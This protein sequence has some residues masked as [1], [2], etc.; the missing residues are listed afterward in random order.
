[1]SSSRSAGQATAP[2]SAG[3]TPPAEPE[4]R[5]P[6]VMIPPLSRTKD[7]FELQF[8]TNHLGHFALTNLLL[9]NITGRVANCPADGEC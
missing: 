2:P 1:M 5:T 9:P 3:S 7:G 8:G 6:G 4:P